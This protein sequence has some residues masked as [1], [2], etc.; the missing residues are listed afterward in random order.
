MNFRKYFNS[1]ISIYRTLIVIIVTLFDIS[2]NDNIN[3]TYIRCQKYKNICKLE[4]S[5]IT[6]SFAKKTFVTALL[7][8]YFFI[9]KKLANHRMHS[10]IISSVSYISDRLNT[11][12]LNITNIFL[13]ITNY[14]E[15]FIDIELYHEQ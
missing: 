12:K 13:S 5:K 14:I 3:K 4:I 10:L 1:S 8:S 6:F 7:T 2:K 9:N 11:K 15:F